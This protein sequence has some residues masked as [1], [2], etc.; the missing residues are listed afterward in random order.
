MKRYILA[1]ETGGTKI[2]L[3][4]G[5]AEGEIL[6]N[7]RT[8]V[9]REEGFYGILEVVTNALPLLMKKAEEF[10]GTI[11]KIGIGFG[12]PVDSKSGVAIWSAQIDGWGDFPVKEFFE[13]KTKIPTY[14]FN[15]STAAAWG[16]YCKGSGRGSNIFFYT[17]IGSGVGGGIIINGKIFDGQGYGAAE[18][19]QSYLCNPFYKGETK[20]SA[21]Q[22]ERVCSGWAIEK[23][24]RTDDIP[25]NSILWELCHHKQETI[26]CLMWAKGVEKEDHYAMKILD[27]TAE[28]F[29]IALSN[30]LCFY[31]PEVIAVGGGVSLIGEPL[32]SR[33][34]DYVK[35]YAYRNTAG[36]YKIVKS[37][38]DEAIVLV[39]TLL[40]TGAEE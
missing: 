7:Y 12:G 21:I 34:N 30:V 37:S 19:G 14:L 10:G 20:F 36:R 17:N 31:S 18:F 23:R 29:A 38:L 22:V 25:E 32:I 26:D 39:G 11:S 3:A 27:E 9:K 8:K 4:I 2:Q 5:T 6:Y 28:L 24:M 15:D 13:E 1:I 35:K 40:L 33:L 16:E